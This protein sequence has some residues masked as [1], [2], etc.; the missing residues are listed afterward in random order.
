VRNDV[1]KDMNKALRRD[2]WDSLT[3]SGAN[4]ALPVWVIDR[5]DEFTAPW[6]PMVKDTEPV[7]RSGP[8]QK[9]GA[10]TGD[11]GKENIYV[12]NRMEETSDEVA[13][14]LQGFYLELEQDVRIG[15]PFV[16]GAE[17]VEG[18]DDVN[19]ELEDNEEKDD[20]RRVREKIDNESKIKEVM[21]VVERTICSLF[22]DRLSF[23]FSF[24]SGLAV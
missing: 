4:V 13:A 3:N 7:L 12:V 1:G 23:K 20:E 11:K 17:G 14:R 22:Y 8:W 21:E 9:T 16:G 2:V 24:S 10:G 18:K 15:G 19:E 6:Y 5:V